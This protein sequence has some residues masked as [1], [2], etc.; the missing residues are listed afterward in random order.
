MFANRKHG[1]NIYTERSI[2]TFQYNFDC[3]HPEDAEGGI[4]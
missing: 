3:V 2:R 1:F 4:L